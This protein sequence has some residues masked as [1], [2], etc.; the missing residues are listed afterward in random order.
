MLQ[1]L[2]VISEDICSVYQI[3][4]LI[5]STNL[6]LLITRNRICGRTV[7][8]LKVEWLKR[9]FLKKDGSHVHI[10]KLDGQIIYTPKCFNY[11][12]SATYSIH[13]HSFV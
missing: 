13:L 3:V 11:S 5:H 2:L 1:C 7:K 10:P 9:P 12:H 6:C 8:T 4:G